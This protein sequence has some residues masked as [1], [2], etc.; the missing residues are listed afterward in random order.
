[1]A[2]SNV[3][4]AFVAIRP[5]T[6][7]LARETKTLVG[8]A[9]Q[10]ITGAVGIDPEM[11]GFAGAVSGVVAKAAKAAASEVDVGAETGTIAG[12]VKSAAAKAAGAAA[13][14][15]EVGAETGSMGGQIKS[16]ASSAAA[17]AAAK[18]EVDADTAKAESKIKSAGANA[19]KVDIEVDADTGRAESSLDGL[20]SSAKV[21]AAAAGVAAGAALAKGIAGSFAKEQLG[22]KLGAQ[23]RLTEGESA[24]VGK[25]AGHLYGDAYGESLGEVND[26]IRQVVAGGLADLNDADLS[27]I[28]EGALA[29]A[30][31]FGEDLN[32]VVR[33]AS[34]LMKN[35]LA[36]NAKDALDVITSG[37]Q[38]SS[39]VAGD[40]LDTF[41]EYPSV[42]RSLG[43]DAGTFLGILENGL[44]AGARDT[45]FVADALKELSIRAIDGSKTSREAY[46]ILGLSADKMAQAIAKGGPS[47]E[48]AFGEIIRSIS[49]VEDPVKRA[50]AGVG[51][52]GTKFE[53]LGPEVVA[54]LDPANAKMGDLAGR[55]DDLASA[56]DNASTKIEGF[57]RQALQKLTELVGG[58]V[59][60][61]IERLAEVLGPVLGPVVDGL[62]SLFGRA[63][64][65]MGGLGAVGE[66][67]APILSR[68]AEVVGEAAAGIRD[69]LGPVVAQVVSYVLERFEA[70]VAWVRENWPAIQ[71]AITHVMNVIE[72][73]IRTVIDVVSAFWRAWGDDIMNVV[74]TT[75]D[76]IF[77]I[78]DSVMKL[79]QGVIE[80]VLGLINGEWGMV[81]DG[82]KNVLAAVWDAMFAIVRGALNLVGSLIAGVLS[83]IREVWNG[84]WS[85]IRDFLAAVWSR[86]RDIVSGAISA[87]RDTIANVLNGIR[88]TWNSVWGGVRDFLGGIWDSIRG[89]A[90]R[91]M[92]GVRD[93]IAGA[94]DGIRGI[95]NR[96]VDIFKTPINAVIR[97]ANT[98]IGGANTILS[99]VDAGT[100][101]RIPS[102][103]S[104][105]VVGGSRDNRLGR[106]GPLH[107]D[108]ELARLQKGEGVLPRAAMKRLGIDGFEA[109]RG[110]G[111]KPLPPGYSKERPLESDVGPEIGGFP[112]S[113]ILKSLVGKGLGTLIDIAGG[114][115]TNATK[116]IVHAGN[117][118]GTAG[119]FAAY[120]PKEAGIKVAVW[121][122]KLKAGLEKEQGAAGTFGTGSVINRLIG[123]V[124]SSGVPHRVTS[125]KRSG[126]GSSYH[127]SGRA[128]DFAGPRPS[129]NSPALAAIF[130]AFRNVESQ[131]KELIYAGP[132]VSYNIKNGRRV[133]KYSQALHKNHVHAALERGGVFTEPFTGMLSLGES[134]K[135]RPE[136]VT[137]AALMRQIVREESG[138]EI[139]LE[140]VLAALDRLTAEVRRVRALNVTFNEKVSTRR[141]LEEAGRRL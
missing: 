66:R 48:A 58:V 116:A 14:D 103:H 47:A 94:V 62:S 2:D 44:A 117:S 86:M 89:G 80:V 105:G 107:D 12:S 57:K 45:D 85:A 126:S 130:R 67:I 23:L 18:V 82:I 55:T 83:G 38:G 121:L 34:T 5:E 19:P 60:P 98:L 74:R 27:G 69:V 119:K 78:I 104:G 110:G 42:I 134:A 16:A 123:V 31:V 81:W 46:D 64:E 65:G 1:M 4:A 68:V 113:G 115:V 124:R 125:T 37:L 87:V 63:S 50:E 92:D 100:I 96:I 127:N 91:A 54:A 21:G 139:D 140:P 138:G 106:T 24:K 108:E 28:T 136:I 102:L 122:A 97:F 120:P 52:L 129:I 141:V 30:D 114:I 71:E 99:K 25:I 22:D 88:N 40:L 76:V 6:K 133:G 20:F 137:P 29:V 56:Y 111:S 36:P 8:K 77:A 11:R 70:L 118:F 49:A 73:V 75:F 39:G 7:N 9:L 35:G 90:S 41:T 131:L 135:A 132:Q 10:R 17:A 101:P 84:I 72:G 13:S 93:T 3:G 128:V 53:D 59:I 112:G 51:L 15:V 26:A 79:V 33:A 43:V 32:G 95:W 61:G 109:L